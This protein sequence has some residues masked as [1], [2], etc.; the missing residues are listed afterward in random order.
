MRVRVNC[1]KKEEKNIVGIADEISPRLPPL[2]SIISYLKL[3]KNKNDNI[4][5][6]ISTMSM[7]IIQPLQQ[8]QQQQQ[9]QQSPKPLNI[10]S[11]AYHLVEQYGDDCETWPE[12]VKIFSESLCETLCSWILD[13][14]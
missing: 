11:A 12:P 9:Q 14:R 3:K 10:M 8:Q 1:F 7:P 4:I 5:D 2:N 13:I 6:E